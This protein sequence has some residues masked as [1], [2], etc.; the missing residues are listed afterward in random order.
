MNPFVF[1]HIPK[2]AG[3]SFRIGADSFFGSESVCRDYG[4]KSPETS[5]IIKVWNAGVRDKWEFKKRFEE[6]R[7]QFL[8]G[9][10]HAAVYAPL[11]GV[12]KMFTFVRDPVQ[13]LVSE[14]HHMVR[15]YR[16]DES[17]EDFYRAPHN[18]NR[19]QRILGRILWPAIGFI[20]LTEMYE[21][22]LYLFNRKY[23]LDI[24]I[25][26]ENLGRI[27]LT[28]NYELP[29]FQEEEL[30]RLNAEDIALYKSIKTQFRWRLKLAET[31]RNFVLGALRQV[32]KERLSGWAIAENREEPIVIQARVGGNIIGVS[33]AIQDRPWLRGMGVGRGGFVGFSFDVSQLKAG[34]KVECVVA[35]TEQP[36]AGSPWTV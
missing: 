2:T 33:H 11:F 5:E 17:F 29:T 14:Y 19:Q 16:Y 8:T 31:G 12:S 26:R 28:D 34:D 36:L 20:G 1:I 4:L 18:I 25:Y 13:R 21:Q 15:N 9:H 6:A 3:T 24:P 22:S 23:S 32:E 10:F 27:N 7:Y 35:S 30:R